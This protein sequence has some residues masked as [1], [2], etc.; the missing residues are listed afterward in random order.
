MKRNKNFLRECLKELQKKLKKASQQKKLKDSDNNKS[1]KNKW[2]K[3]SNP[4][5]PANNPN[6]LFKQEDKW[7]KLIKMIINLQN[8]TK[9]EPQKSIKRKEKEIR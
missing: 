9:A 4:I 7:N 6:P 5:H 2:I 1:K 8:T 3:S